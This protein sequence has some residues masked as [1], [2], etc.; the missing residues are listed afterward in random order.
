VATRKLTSSNEAKAERVGGV[1]TGRRNEYGIGDRVR[2]GRERLGWSR[3]TLAFRSGLSSS[4][5]AQL[6]SGRRRNTQ[7]STLSALS[8]AIGVTID[9]L[10]RGSSSSPAMLGHRSLAYSSDKEF[11]GAAGSF[12]SKAVEQSEP[13]LAVFSRKNI[14]LLRDDLGAVA[15]EIE[16]R[17][18]GS[19]YE[20]PTAALKAYR[21]FL[22]E[23]IEAGARWLHVAGE[24]VWGGSKREIRIWA[25]YESLA[26]LTFSSSPATLFCFYDQRALDPAIVD[27]ARLTHPEIVENGEV[28]ANPLYREPG[29][30][31]L[32]DQPDG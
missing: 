13:A 2:A 10:V 20:S 4:A 21:S 23:K 12:L 26:N 11:V 18:A 30:F 31:V 29:E 17:E 22:E 3:D 28:T 14:G 19:W 9:Y 16:F 7:P 24:A 5:I 8:Q 25:E 15:R 6:E 1:S 32:A 27:A